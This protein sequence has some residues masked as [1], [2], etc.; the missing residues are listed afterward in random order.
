MWG[1]SRPASIGIE[2]TDGTGGAFQFIRGVEQPR[3]SLFT[4]RPKNDHSYSSKA[5]RNN[6]RK[7]LGGTWDD[8]VCHSRW[9]R[10]VDVWLL[11]LFGQAPLFKVGE[12]FAHALF[13]ILCL[14]QLHVIR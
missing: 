7:E 13:F 14:V 1:P 11:V 2:G 10:G 9:K 3:D 6:W 8:V 5:G 12:H 4:F